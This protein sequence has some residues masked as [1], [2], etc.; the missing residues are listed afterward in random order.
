MRYIGSKILLLE[1]IRDLV[2]QKAPDAK[3]FC[4][5]FSGTACVG[6]FFKQWYQVFSN[7]LLYFSYCLQRGTIEND[8]VPEFKLLQSTLGIGDPI[9]YINNLPIEEKERLPKEKRLFQNNFSPIGGRMYVQDINALRIDFARNTIDNWM[10]AK[11]IN[12]DEYFYLLAACIEGIPF[13]SNISGTYG[14]FHKQWEV[15]TFKK[16]EVQHLPVNSNGKYN[17]C[18]REDGIDLVTKISG[19]VLYIDPPYNERQY[20]PNYHVLETAARYDFPQLTGKTGMRENDAKSDF[21]NRK[22]ALLALERL[23]A[24]AN[25]RHVILSY[26]T[27]GIM[28]LVN[29][30]EIMKRHGDP[31][32]F[33]IT[34][35][36]YRRYKSRETTCPSELKEM[37]IYVKK[38]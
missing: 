4:D 21:C 7:D 15:R 18:Y 13:V 24:G 35:I 25:F 36:P 9:D 33:S 8:S 30:E 22:K 12:D 28:P 29:I 2:A 1:N 31:A 3:S 5:I 17:K 23:V 26:N 37:L 32:S 14:A 38:A 20:L 11:L 34:Q 16:F 19:D 27:D 10:A 6:R